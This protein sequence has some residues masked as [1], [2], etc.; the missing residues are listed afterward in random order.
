MS[1]ATMPTKN[2]AISS[3]PSMNRSIALRLRGEGEPAS[4]RA[5]SVSPRTFSAT[6]ISGWRSGAARARHKKVEAAQLRR[7]RA[8]IVSERS[9]VSG[10]F[11]SELFHDRVGV[12][13][14]LP[15]IVGPFLRKRLCSFSPFPDLLGRKRV[16]L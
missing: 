4:F 14:G 9:L 5:T 13:A 11:V 1:A 6:A 3:M 7:R 16:D 15:H 2:A 10:E 12:A 8:A